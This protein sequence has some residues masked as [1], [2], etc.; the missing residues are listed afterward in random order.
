MDKEDGDEKFD[1]NDL[2][3]EFVPFVPEMPQ[4]VTDMTPTK[5]TRELDKV[6]DAV[7]W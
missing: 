3:D 2:V 4:A 6:N 1:D 7:P 5:A